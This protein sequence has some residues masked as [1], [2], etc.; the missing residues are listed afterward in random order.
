ML[1]NIAALVGT[2]I[3]APVTAFDSIQTVTVGAG[4]AASVSFTS[5]PS[6]Y[7]HL[8]IRGFGLDSSAW[9][10]I[11]F[12]GVTSGY[13]EHYLNGDGASAYGGGGTSKARIPIVG[14][15]SGVNSTSPAVSIVDILDYADTNK[16]KTV[17]ALAGIDKNGSG[18][19]GM[20]SG[21]WAS[22]SAITSIVIY[23]GGGNLTQ[24]STYALYGVL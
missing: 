6:T 9:I 15:S 8:Q 11:Q 12:N 14:A 7:K 18:E 19:A 10:G 3:S 5:I 24:Y 17:R 2:P 20:T 1:N 16:N 4:G 23:C 13:T 22:T 21:L